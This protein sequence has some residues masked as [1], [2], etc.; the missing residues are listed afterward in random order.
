MSTPRGLDK[1][2]M[3]IREIME[4]KIYLDMSGNAQSNEPTE[5]F[6]ADGGTVDLTQPVE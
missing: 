5:D 4:D 2:T 3:V 1:F 6:E